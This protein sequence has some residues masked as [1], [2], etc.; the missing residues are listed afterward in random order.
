MQTKSQILRQIIIPN[1]NKITNTTTKPYEISTQIPQDTR[2]S[3]ESSKHLPLWNISSKIVRKQGQKEHEASNFKSNLL[4][5]RDVL[6][7]SGA[8]FAGAQV[9]LLSLGV[10]ER[11]VSLY[12]EGDSQSSLCDVKKMNF[13]NWLGFRWPYV[14]YKLCSSRF[15]KA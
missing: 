7:T 1:V 8:I 13:Q 9:P 5:L 14:I 11:M 3:T 2:R 15:S 4:A 6:G 10:T 12:S